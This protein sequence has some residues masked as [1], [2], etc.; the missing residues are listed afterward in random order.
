MSTDYIL[1]ILLTK[2]ALHCTTLQF[3]AM[4][5]SAAQYSVEQLMQC[6]AIQSIVIQV[7]EDFLVLV[8]LSTYV[9]R[10]IVSCMQEFFFFTNSA[11]LGRVGHRVAM[12]VCLC[13]CLRH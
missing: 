1:P 8:L 3:S 5:Y 13:V 12:C 11:R 2:K 7:S 10:F 6:S 9:A 4:Q